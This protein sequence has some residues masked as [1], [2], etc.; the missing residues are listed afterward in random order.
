MVDFGGRPLGRLCCWVVMVVALVGVAVAEPQSGASTTTV[1][2]TVYLADGT[3][4]SGTL[5]IS[6]PAFLTSGGTAVAG[7]S[8]SVAL[9]SNGALNVALVSNVGASPAG[10]YYSVT[11]Q[12]GPGEVKTEYWL[13]PTSTTAVNLAAVRTT[14]GAG[15]AAQAVSMQYVNSQL[16]TVVHLCGT[17][18]ITGAKTFS[19]SPTVPTPTTSAAIANKAYVDT[20]VSNVG[21]GNYLPTAGGTMTGPIT[22]PANPVSALQASTKQYVDTGLA[23]KSDLIAGLVPA[24]EL[25][26]GLPSAGN[27]LLGNGASGTWGTCGSG[28]GTGNISINP[29][30]T[31]A[32]AQPAG[33][34]FSANNLANIRYVTASWN[35]G[36]TPADNL[37][38]A[39]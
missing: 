9:G 31:Q 37:G 33:T 35:W 24:N 6:W 22:L 3:P 10:V 11:Y 12:L 34:Q 27:C 7:G 21:A 32:I 39:G 13:V 28:G 8:T 36:Q 14:P 38:T 19:N 23:A 5:I 1:A 20:S 25:G 2:D 29:V 30:A 17:E 26:T 4:A 15:S 16:A 18:T